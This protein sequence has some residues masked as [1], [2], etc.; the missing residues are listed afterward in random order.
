VKRR[1]NEIFARK[2]RFLQK[3]SK[4]AAENGSVFIFVKNAVTFYSK[5]DFLA[6]SR[7]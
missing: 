7:G 1:E 4:S 2:T 6:P 5:S 3:T